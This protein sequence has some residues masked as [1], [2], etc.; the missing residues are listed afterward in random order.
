MVFDDIG[1]VDC[2]VYMGTL[3]NCNK[4]VHIS[5]IIVY[6]SIIMLEKVFKSHGDPEAR[7]W[8]V[9]P[10]GEKIKQTNKTKK[11]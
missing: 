4:T 5:I 2:V 3:N 8:C 10:L 1:V 7:T 6:R 11:T 9:S